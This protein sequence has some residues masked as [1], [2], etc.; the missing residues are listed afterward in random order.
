MGNQ[1]LIIALI[2]SAL[3]T[4][5]VGLLSDLAAA[6]LAPSLAGQPLL[7]FVALIV[8]FV[9]ALRVSIYLFVSDR[10]GVNASPETAS[11]PPLIAQPSMVHVFV[12]EANNRASGISGAEVTLVLPGSPSIG[13]TIHG[14][15]S[16]PFTSAFAGRR[17]GISALKPGYKSPS[18]MEVVLTRDA[19]FLIPLE[20]EDDRVEDLISIDPFIVGP[21]VQPDK[22]VG[23]DDELRTILGRLLNRGQSAAIIGQPRIGKSSLLLK[24]EYELQRI[25]RFVDD[26][27]WLIASRVDLHDFDGNETPSSFWE[28]ALKPLRE[29]PGMPETKR[30]LDSIAQE[31]YS[32][33]S[34]NSLFNYLKGQGRLV[35]LLDE[36]D[37]LMSEHMKNFHDYNFFAKF[38]V[39][40]AYPSFAYVTAS[41][42]S[43][44]EFTKWCKGLHEA[45]GSEPFN[46]QIP[47]PLGGFSESAANKLLSWAG[48]ALSNEV[49]RRFIRRVAGSSPYLLQAMASA[50]LNI[51][52]EDRYERATDLFFGMI[53]THFSEVWDGLD[54]RTR[55]MAMILCAVEFGGNDIWEAL[56]TDEIDPTAAIDEELQQL[57]TCCLAARVSDN[58][59]KTFYW[60]NVMWASE[61]SAFAWWIRDKRIGR[62]FS[63]F[64]E[65]S[66]HRLLLSNL[67]SERFEDAMRHRFNWAWVGIKASARALYDE[68]TK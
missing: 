8:T 2:L 52:G 50:F 21:S 64:L 59:K 9:I 45:G 4:L 7:V 26:I 25:D 47:I 57:A 61:S 55:A 12:H 58:R 66:P 33:D 36:F 29:H 43:L 22:F 16:L 39:L 28:K 24:L 40:D 44:E 6:Y 53:P 11:S 68:M 60:Q 23:R 51:K 41:R 20:R 34:L 3:F 37:R 38:H 10:R 49:D 5:I 35:L 31:R 19:H 1:R 14:A 54:N 18:P 30:Q 27:Q 62:S 67:Q 63:G 32:R 65:K 42:K 48:E 15:V 13:T 17:C 56:N 46:T